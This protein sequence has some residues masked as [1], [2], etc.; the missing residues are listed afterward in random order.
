MASQIE[1]NSSCASTD[2][3]SQASR[4]QTQRHTHFVRSTIFIDEID[5]MKSILMQ[6]PAYDGAGGGSSN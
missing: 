4:Q 5:E 3:G 2:I 6:A 1:W